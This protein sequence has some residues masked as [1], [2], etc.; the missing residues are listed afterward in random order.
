MADSA[1]GDVTQMPEPHPGVSAAAGDG[2][3]GAKGSGTTRTLLRGLDVIEALSVADSGGS[4]PS[5]IGD[6][7]GLDKATVSRLLRTLVDAGW[8]RRD[9]RTRHYR[10]S[11]R[12]RPLG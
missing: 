3:T 9:P 10:L 11:G 6:A 12:D 4:G 5:A 8:V 2:K 1:L 7:V